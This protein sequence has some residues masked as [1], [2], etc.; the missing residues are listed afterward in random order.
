MKDRLI[1]SLENIPKALYGC[2]LTVGNFDGVHVGHQRIVQ[3]CAELA[4]RGGCAAVAMTF[5]PPPDLVLRPGDMPQRIT[6]TDVKAKLLREVGADYVVVA[7]STASLL[8]MSPQEFI[9]QVIIGR[10][11]PS[12]VVEGENFRFGHGRSGDVE[13]LASDAAGGFEV[14][15]V[16]PVTLELPG[17]PQRVS[18][19]LI[20]RLISAGDVEAANRCL[21]GAFVLFGEVIRG[22]GRGAEQLGFPTANVQTCEQIIPADG[23]YAGR[24]RCGDDEY[25]AA[26]SI[27]TRPTLGSGPRAV[28]A[29]LMDLP[30]DRSDF[31]GRQLA[32]AFEARLRGQAAFDST[33]DLKAQIAKDVKRV[34][35]LC[36]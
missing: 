19:T 10:F 28:E 22:T 3:R 14:H 9:E 31:Y 33:A 25:L 12:A 30:P 1:K 11:A 34:R 24:A 5:D 26:I 16:E 27:G 36:G 4:G 18:S 7:T 35:E 6:P 23:V 8:E 21:G 29:Y 13:T 20:R 32:L 17:G 15:V 2:V